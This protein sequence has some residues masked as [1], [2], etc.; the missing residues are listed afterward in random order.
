MKH[1]VSFF[2]SLKIK[3]SFVVLILSILPILIIG[4]L[5]YKLAAEAMEE[6]GMGQI[7]DTLEG[8]YNLVLQYYKRVKSGELTKEQA[9]KR[10]YDILSGPVK[11]ASVKFASDEDAKSFFKLLDIEVNNID[12]NSNYLII[13]GRVVGKYISK[14]KSY[15]ITD[16]GFLNKFN[17][18]FHKLKIEKQYEL[19]ASKYAVRIIYDFSK[20]VVK[21]RNSGYVWAVTGN[22]GGQ[23]EGR[24]Y[25]AFHP[26]IGGLNV[27]NAKNYQGEPVGRTISNMKDSIDNVAEGEIVRYD[28]FWK[29]PTDPAP[30]KK[31]VLM[32]YFK[33][34]NW[35]IC[36]GLYEDEFFAYLKSIRKSIV[37]GTIISSIVAF[38]LT[39]LMLMFVLS[40]ITKVNEKIALITDGDLTAEISTKSSDEIGITLKNLA[41]MNESLKTIVKKV[42]LA[43]EVVEDAASTISEGNEDLAKR[44]EVQ[45]VSIEETSAAMEE[46]TSIV[47]KNLENAEGADKFAREARANA[48]QGESVVMRSVEAMGKINDAARKISEIIKVIDEIAFQTNLL[49]VNAAV[50]AAR[51]GEFGKGFAVVAV[52]VRNLAGRSSQAAK[53]IYNLIQDTN[54]KVEEG[55]NLVNMSGKVFGNISEGINKL[56]DFISEVAAT[57]REYHEG[58]EEV[59]KAIIKMDDMTQ[60]NSTLVENV[61]AA[62]REML[63]RIDDLKEGVGFF[64]LGD[65]KYYETEESS[66]AGGI[67]YRR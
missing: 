54:E 61:T 49:A 51:A 3:I 42:H 65:E 36:S 4:R 18:N 28:Y 59:N 15:T 60:K 64:N 56:A 45:A 25:E 32:K 2:R 12:L 48:T 24:A 38:S 8:G 40:R 63:E 30:R 10:I 67:T 7:K 66:N 22:P 50:E 41:A 43:T 57:S 21:I 53:E 46:M 62:S 39:F 27:W 29:N 19:A 58:I 34:F 47:K 37:V 31:I 13:A 44:T 20:A 6:A 17:D 33:P 35:V 14:T 16:A 1:R 9:V 55:S 23:F 5:S 11:S 26:A 52:E